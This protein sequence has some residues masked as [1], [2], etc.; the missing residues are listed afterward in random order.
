MTVQA[1]FNPHFT[2][3][4]SAEANLVFKNVVKQEFVILLLMNAGSIY[5]ENKYLEIPANNQT[6]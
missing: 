1:S 3:C 4:T 5:L 6:I 2:P